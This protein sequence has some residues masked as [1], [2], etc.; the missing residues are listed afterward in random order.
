MKFK[1]LLVLIFLS[2][3]LFSLAETGDTLHLSVAV[4]M[5]LDKNY[6][7][8]LAQNNLEIARI[9]NSPGNAGM[10]PKLDITGTRSRA[11][12]NSHMEYFD[13]RTRDG[14]N[15]VTNVTNAGM[16]LS[17]TFFDGFNMFIQRDKLNQLEE[18][19]N[20]QLQS[21]VENTVSQVIRVYFE[22]AAQQK[23]AEVY[24]EA[25]KISHERLV[26]SKARFNLGAGSELGILQAMVDLSADSANFIRQMALVKNLK[27]DL[28]FLLC[29]NL[30]TLFDVERN[31]PL[32]DDIVYEDVRKKM[33]DENP[34][35][36]LARN[37][38]DLSSLAI[39]ELRTAHYPKLSLNSSYSYN[40]QKAE[41]GIYN[42]NR[43]LGLNVGV[44]LSYNIFNGFTNRQKIDAARIRQESALTGLKLLKHEQETSLL[45]IF[46]DY[47][48]NLQLVNFETENLSFANRNFSI[49]KERYK[50]GAITDVELRETQKKLMDAENRLLMARFRCKSAEI[51]LLRLSGQLSKE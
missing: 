40:K 10:L 37:E 19:S 32:R 6:S 39:R 30:D 15:A 22:I 12:N 42:L 24:Q 8:T 44:T 13:G 46:N 3:R 14:K 25:M 17:W 38:V 36:R 51:E 31:I 26:F 9:N 21:V 47:Q 34:E 35:L 49:A 7:I 18:M 11:Q 20:V 45:Q 1:G 16:Q 5:A 28:N 4:S 23:L 43:N 50:L 48:T 41:I 2:G 33:D 29:R 27:A